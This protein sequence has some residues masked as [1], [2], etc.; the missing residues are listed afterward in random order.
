MGLMVAVSGCVQME[1][2]TILVEG[3]MAVGTG[4]SVRVVRCIERA[5]LGRGLGGD[6][7]QCVRFEPLQRVALTTEGS[8]AFVLTPTFPGSFRLDAIGEGTTRLTA[9][10]TTA[11]GEELSERV[12]VEARVPASQRTSCLKCTAPFAWLPGEKAIVT[13]WQLTDDAGIELWGKAEYETTG[14]LTADPASHPFR[15]TATDAGEGRVRAV[16][17]A[18]RQVTPDIVVQVVPPADVS[19]LVLASAVRSDAGEA[20]TSLPLVPSTLSLPRR[21]DGTIA[22]RQLE[23]YPM[24]GLSDGGLAWS[25]P[26]NIRLGLPDG[27]SSEPR[28]LD[29]RCTL[30]LPGPGTFTVSLD[31]GARTLSSVLTAE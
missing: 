23:V 6:F 4:Q 26:A 14:S 7:N 15:I 17:A 13:R 21:N 5:P 18:V 29:E 12:D 16:S 28:C 2:L 30:F 22:A 11:A 20:L 9:T 1:G 19:S 27:G 3:P 10:A 25:D 31:L 8:S 24:F